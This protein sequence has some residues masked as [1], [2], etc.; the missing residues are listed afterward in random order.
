M[1][2]AYENDLFDSK[3]VALPESFHARRIWNTIPTFIH[4]FDSK[5]GSVLYNFILTNVTVLD[6][7]GQMVQD[8]IGADGKKDYANY[9]TAPGWSQILDINRCPQYALPWLAQFVGVELNPNWTVQRSR[10]EIARRTNFQ[11]GTIVNLTRALV[12]VVNEGIAEIAQ[13]ITYDDVIVLEQTR[14]VAPYA[15]TFVGTNT[16][17]TNTITVPYNLELLTVG[18]LVTGGTGVPSGTTITQITATSTH[19]GT[20]NVSA[21]ITS[22]NTGATF[23]GN[24]QKAKYIHDDY[25]MC[26]LMPSRF[27]LAFSYGNLAAELNVTADPVQYIDIE[28]AIKALSANESYNNLTLNNSP[29]TNSRFLSVIYRERP[30]GIKIY[31]GGY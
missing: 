6:L 2:I 24:L 29:N 22:G 27:Y 30:T 25:A 13:V 28:N 14:Y 17:G 26:V 11:R 9:P 15:Q 4:Q 31:I 23:T 20:V 18:M 3:G 19:S 12:D 1:T 8:N 5:N 7:I 16:T 21:N 10:T